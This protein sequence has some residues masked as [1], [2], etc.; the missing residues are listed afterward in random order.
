LINHKDLL[1]AYFREKSIVEFNIESFNK[2][3]NERMQVV[4][5]EVGKLTPDILPPNVSD[6][7]IVFGKVWVEKP[8][9]READGTKRPILPIEARLRDLTYEAPI[10][11]EMFYKKDGVEGEKKVI[12]IGNMPIMV[13]S[14][15]C[16]LKGLSR[17]ELIN[18]GEDPMD[19]GGYFIIN[20]TER[21]VVI[22]EDLAPNRI[23]VEE[24]KI[25][26]YPYIVKI[27]SEDD[28]LRIPHL[29]QKSRAGL[30]NVT[31][32]RVNKAP[33]MLLLKALGLDNDKEIVSAIQ[34]NE[35]MMS[36]IYINLYKV[37]E[38]KN[39]KQA[40]IA[41]GKKLGATQTEEKMIN[42]AL[43][44]IDKFLFPHIGHDESS[45]MLKA[46]Y[47][48]KC[49]RKLLQLSY[50]IIKEDDK[51]HY[52][53]KRLRLCGDL[54]E[55][56][57]RFSFRILVGDMKYNF[58]RLVKR[59]K[60]PSLQAIT[61]SQL[62]SSRIKSNLATG[63]W[64]G[65]RH[66]VSQHLSRCNFVDTVSHLKRVVSSLTSSRENFEAR[67]I[68]PTHWGKLCAYETPE[69]PPVGLRKYLGITCEISTNVPKEENEKIVEAL[70][71]SGLEQI[72]VDKK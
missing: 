51:D 63:E 19:P 5:D 50:N 57:F 28:Q 6:F 31:F 10:M 46:Y 26:P 14:D 11:L 58:E 72:G 43:T 27:F 61:R 36:D 24:Q 38:I 18:N 55:S 25:G 49:I 17:E 13:K 66:G 2:F 4:V 22:I 48:A 30:I 40:L 62:L 35:R 45:R 65:G 21:V 7:E 71:N 64:V 68:H 47:L 3:I 44:M 69:G 12:H 54:M 9:I 60:L 23:F 16:Y 39:Q 52:M 59:G 56:L 67:D 29:I 8:L 37:A 34:P 1:R 53:N 33:A 32:T 41:L 20:G 42:K 70:K 15:P